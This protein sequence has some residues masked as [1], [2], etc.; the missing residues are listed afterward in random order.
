MK[1]A[2]PLQNLVATKSSKPHSTLKFDYIVN[3]CSTL[4]NVTVSPIVLPFE[5]WDKCNLEA[6]ILKNE[7]ALPF[8]T[9]VS[10]EIVGTLCCFLALPLLVCKIWWVYCNKQHWDDDETGQKQKCRVEVSQ[11]FLS[12][13]VAPPSQLRKLTYF[14]QLFKYFP[15]SCIAKYYSHF[16]W[17]KHIFLLFFLFSLFS[18]FFSLILILLFFSSNFHI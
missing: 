17:Y 6:Q 4:F 9:T 15:F 18:T 10:V 13:I 7:K 11:L 3:K 16:S 5:T 1:D 14:G 2:A 8:G 12:E